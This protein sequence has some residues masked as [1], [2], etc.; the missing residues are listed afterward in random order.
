MERTRLSAETVEGGKSRKQDKEEEMDEIKTEKE[1]DEAARG[2]F[3]TFCVSRRVQL[4]STKF[5]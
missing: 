4:S 1:E 5:F 2:I 3:E